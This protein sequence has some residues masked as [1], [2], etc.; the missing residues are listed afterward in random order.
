M[1]GFGLAFDHF[2]LATRDADRTLKFL[3]ALGY[4]TPEA[5]HDPLQDV[6]L[7]Y[8]EHRSMPPVEVV[9]AASETGPLDAILA[10]QPQCIYHMCF[11]TSDL[12]ATLKS[13]KAAGHRVAVVAEPK[14]AVLFGYRH[15]SFYMV[16]GFGLIEILEDRS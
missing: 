6:N 2:G 16:R 8:C 15:V 7:V 10:Q 5:T 11:R 9:F 3:R 13:M 14:P 12:A 1:P 4:G